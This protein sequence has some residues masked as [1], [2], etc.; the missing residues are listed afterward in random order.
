[1]SFRAGT[2]AKA[3]VITYRNDKD[4]DLDE[5]IGVYRRST[6][7]ERRP[8]H[9]RAIMAAMLK[10]ADI[11]ISAWDR[12]RLVGLARTLTDY[13]YVAY[14]A[15]LA[16]DLAYQRQGIGKQLVDRTRAALEATCFITLLAAPKANDYYPRIGFAHN[17][18][19]WTLAPA[20]N[21]YAPGKAPGF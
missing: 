10:H 15:D 17:P 2:A 4:I 12:T 1:M 19:A 5:F 21:P 8:I 11:L 13:A 16:V 3:N 7:G 9:D 6:L 20:Q 14:L 18:R